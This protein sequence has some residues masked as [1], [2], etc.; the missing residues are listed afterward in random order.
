MSRFLGHGEVIPALVSFGISMLA[1]CWAWMNYSWF[2]SAYDA[3]GLSFRLAT[4]IHMVGVI[5]FAL[6]VP[7][8]FQSV[9]E[10]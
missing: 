7:R 8:L 3:D 5:V 10:G 9:A 2:A 4:M 6:G 1:I